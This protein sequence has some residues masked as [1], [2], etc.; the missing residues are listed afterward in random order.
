VGSLLCT[1]LKKE[2]DEESLDTGLLPGNVS[3]APGLYRAMRP[4]FCQLAR[5]SRHS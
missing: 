1:N 2:L 4:V 3:M 5:A